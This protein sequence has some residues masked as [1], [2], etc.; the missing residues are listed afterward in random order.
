MVTIW[1]RERGSGMIVFAPAEPSVLRIS[2]PQTVPTIL[3]VPAGR[4]SAPGRVP[5]GSVVP[6]S[7]PRRRSSPIS[8]TCPDAEGAARVLL[9]RHAPPLLEGEHLAR[10]VGDELPR[11]E[12]DVVVPAVVLLLGDRLGHLLALVRRPVGIG[13]VVGEDRHAVAL[14]RALDDGHV[15]HE[16]VVVDVHPLGLPP[17]VV[18]ERWLGDRR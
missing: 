14:L 3:G 10:V 2:S 18:V 9:V 16:A 7:A 11:S 17:A 13:A 1:M 5:A 4:G 15:E 6:G 12:V 8:T